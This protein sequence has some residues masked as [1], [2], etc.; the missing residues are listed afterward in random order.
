MNDLATHA[1][2]FQYTFE[3]ASATLK[4]FLRDDIAI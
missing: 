3:Q 2:I 4:H 1:K